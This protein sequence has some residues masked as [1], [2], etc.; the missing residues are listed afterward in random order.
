[1]VITRKQ[2][3]CAAVLVAALL[4]YALAGFYLLPYLIRTQLPVILKEQ[5]GQ[6]AQLQT[7]RFNPFKFLLELENFSLAGSDGKNLIS[8]D[9]F[10]VDFNA[11][12]SVRRQA[13]VFDN[14]VLSKPLLDIKRKSDGSFNFSS[15]LPKTEPA[16]PTEDKKNTDLLPLMLHSFSIQEGRIG[17]FDAISGQELRDSLLPVNLSVTEL[18]T[19][20]NAE[21]G[22]DLGF[23]LES[24]GH[25][26]WQGVF[27]L[28]PI[29][30]KG[31]IDL[32]DLG[33]TNVWR[34]FLQ[35]ILPV[36]ITA[37]RLSVSAEYQA[38]IAES[39]MALN[40]SNGLI[41]VKEFAVAEKGKSDP[42]LTIPMLAVSGISA[43]LDK[44]EVKINALSSSDAQIKAV[45]Q[46]DGILN[47]QA[48]FAQRATATPASAQQTSA[49]AG[50]PGPEWQIS[51]G[52]LALKNYQLSFIKD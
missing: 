4:L 35:K 52:E 51:L 10:V 30:S 6:S 24:G 45:L 12:S 21:A 18:T 8:F 23:V 44:H 17:W 41:K 47:Y 29:T 28:T 42:L 38:G 11:I 26:H 25:L 49:Q 50:K 1:M 37:G 31:K 2:K 13:L 34:L 15:M 3:I 32:E 40:L 39:G 7:V 9:S 36:Q 48:I 14:I 43:N 5:T 27:G 33:L 46:A 16:K 22:F 19:Q 20:G